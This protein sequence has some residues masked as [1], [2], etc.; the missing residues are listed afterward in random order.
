[1]SSEYLV[2]NKG[3]SLDDPWEPSAHAP[4]PFR[5]LFFDERLSRCA[6]LAK[7]LAAAE[8]DVLDRTAADPEHGELYEV[9]WTPSNECGNEVL[10]ASRRYEED[11]ED[12]VLGAW[13]RGAE[14]A[15]DGAGANGGSGQRSVSPRL[16]QDEPLLCSWWT[17]SWADG[18]TEQPVR[19][20]SS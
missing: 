16:E 7:K 12:S 3:P 9:P 1:M 8:G 15:G 5:R 13:S 17:D 10:D 18:A 6:A 11:E 19:T 14:P 2:A 20:A 4:F